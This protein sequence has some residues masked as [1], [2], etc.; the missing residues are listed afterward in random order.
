VTSERYKEMSE[1]S[2]E[3]QAAV[4]T[5]GQICPVCHDGFLHIKHIIQPVN[6]GKISIAFVICDN[7][8]A[9][10]EMDK[11]LQLLGKPSKEPRPGRFLTHHGSNDMWSE[12]FTT[13]HLEPCDC[14]RVQFKHYR[15]RGLG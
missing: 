8:G 15:V 12:E 7:C 5:P 11:R 3:G 2:H 6:E 9:N 13:D 14:S 1:H 4:I 10:W